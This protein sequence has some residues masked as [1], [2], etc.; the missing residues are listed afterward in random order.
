M[1]DFWELALHCVTCSVSF[2]LCAILELGLTT[3][4][5]KNVDDAGDPS[6]SVPV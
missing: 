2:G 4:E 3:F 1:F 6:L 5:L